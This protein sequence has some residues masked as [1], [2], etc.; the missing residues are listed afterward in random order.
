MDEAGRREVPVARVVGRT[1]ARAVVAGAILAA[2]AAVPAALVAAAEP[3]QVKR[4]FAAATEAF[5]AAKPAESARLFD[6]VAAAVPDRE[7]ELWQRGLA[8]YYAGRYADGRRQFEL[9]RTVNPND[10]ENVAWHFACVARAEGAEQARAALLP[11]GP[12]RRVPMTEIRDLFAGTGTAE[13]VLEAA[14][15]GPESARRNQRCYAHLYLGLYYDALGDEERAR[16]HI[17]QAAGPF[18]MDHY[19]GKVARVHAQV[20]G[21]PLPPGAAASDE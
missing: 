15:R 12:D 18:S 20:R 21:W 5:F 3:G 13:G 17:L 2:A 7:P 9:H 16:E 10:V 4:D 19:M 14:E 11:V 6:A 8:L 1:Q